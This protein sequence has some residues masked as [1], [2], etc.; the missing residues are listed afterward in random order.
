MEHDFPEQDE[1]EEVHEQKPS[2]EKVQTPSEP[3]TETSTGVTSDSEKPA[4]QTAE[5]AQHE[6]Q[7]QHVVQT[8]GEIQKPSSDEKPSAETEGHIEQVHESTVEPAEGHIEQI[9]SD[10]STAGPE[11]HIEQVHSDASTGVPEEID[12]SHLST[13]GPII[14]ENIPSDTVPGLVSIPDENISGHTDTKIEDILIPTAVPAEY[15]GL[16][17]SIK[18]N[19]IQ[20]IITELLHP[21][22]QK[23]ID[24]NDLATSSPETSESETGDKQGEADKP[25]ISEDSE[26]TIP[27]SPEEIFHSP[28]SASSNVPIESASSVLKPEDENIIKEQEPEKSGDNSAVTSDQGEHFQKPISVESDSIPVQSEELT[29]ES[30]QT[31]HEHP[32][33]TETVDS[34]IKPNEVSSEESPVVPDQATLIEDQTKPEEP[35]HI[36][37][38]AHPGVPGA[39][40][41]EAVKP[42]EPAVETP[43][44]STGEPSVET[45]DVPA[46]EASVEQQTAE[47]PSVDTQTE[48]VGVDETKLGEPVHGETLDVSEHPPAAT[49]I[50]E[51]ED[52]PGE[53]PGETSVPSEHEGST[54]SDE[55]ANKPEEPS[56]IDHSAVPEQPVTAI[57][58]DLPTEN[59]SS[60][61]NSVEVDQLPVESDQV[62]TKPEESSSDIP[63]QSVQHESEGTVQPETQDATEKPETLESETVENKPEE[64]TTA[65][66]ESGESSPEQP[67]TVESD[68]SEQI[69]EKTSHGETEHPDSNEV[70]AKP[71]VVPF[72]GIPAIPETI[73]SDEIESNQEEHIDPT[74]LPE[75]QVPVESE[76]ESTATPEHPV[77]AV[78]DNLPDKPEETPAATEQPSYVESDGGT[79]KPD[80]VSEEQP[81]ATLDIT[82]QPI[83]ESDES[84]QKPEE[85]H[86]LHTE[87]T[88]GIPQQPSAVESDDAA[89]PEESSLQPHEDTVTESSETSETSEISKPHETEDSSEP[90]SKPDENTIA[91]VS[92]DDHLHPT[93]STQSEGTTESDQSIQPVKSEEG[94]NQIPED[95]VKPEDNKV[96]DSTEHEATVLHEHEQSPAVS[97]ETESE[98]EIVDATDKPVAEEVV[99]GKLDNVVETVEE[100]P[101]PSSDVQHETPITDSENAVA[102]E[103]AESEKPVEAKPLDE[104]NAIEDTTE[105]KPEAPESNVIHDSEQN[106]ISETNTAVPIDSVSEGSHL[107][108]V[109]ANEQSSESDGATTV[110]TIVPLTSVESDE[111]QKPDTTKESSESFSSEESSVPSESDAVGVESSTLHAAVNESP[112]P[113]SESHE[114]PTIPEDAQE[115]EKN[116]FEGEGSNQIPEQSFDS[117]PTSQEETTTDENQTSIPHVSEDIDKPGNTDLPT[118]SINEEPPSESDQGE[119]QSHVESNTAEVP[120][121]EVDKEPGKHD[122]GTIAPETDELS[123]P[124]ESTSVDIL[125]GEV[126]PSETSES[127]VHD[128]AIDSENQVNGEKPIAPEIIPQSSDAVNEPNRGEEAS[129]P[130]EIPDAAGPIHGGAIDIESITQHLPGPTGILSSESEQGIIPGEGSCLV[131]DVTYSNNSKIPSSSPCHKKCVCISSIV[132]CIQSD[133]PPPPPHLSNC[134]PIQQ[135]PDSCCPMYACGKY[136]KYNNIKN[137]K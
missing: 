98:Q 51:T 4:D 66:A 117:Q 63:Q 5:T 103:L 43:A 32:V 47:G 39:D 9:H 131:D 46:E 123:K 73:V 18:N 67:A 20:S 74:V 1:E 125:P 120:I 17:E 34:E 93:E 24:V 26:G 57:S 49:E 68:H 137:K 71:E 70:V 128:L 16:E 23:P 124:E 78:S 2:D 28:D 27:T 119:L 30:E 6:E 19:T 95:S 58:E 86:V 87:T 35:L 82:E 65:E 112:I 10:E 92:N 116:V 59:Y 90:E 21:E 60:V 113:S 96:E 104:G 38:T 48:E 53:L 91:E 15:P 61:T 12:D 50:V 108:P 45:T 101:H 122:A 37:P 115:P 3:E 126:K 22:E 41:I 64:H 89:K 109:D 14:S 97:D 75:H 118:P 84:A 134:M 7:I 13:S 127:S 83:A 114:L 121:E 100:V 8:E 135:G 107:S 31:V 105:I 106:V 88:D 77:L 136:T 111:S 33:Q 132:H 72:V 110:E 11:G 79:V 56:I 62:A 81:T 52:K 80:E 76:A 55:S 85:H 130:N 42:E 102:T 40:E 54:E 94:I 129:S 29:T 36:E 44:A 25:E 99:P 69:P 133:C